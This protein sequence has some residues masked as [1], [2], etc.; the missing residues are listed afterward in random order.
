MATEEN[1]GGVLEAMET[2]KNQIQEAPPIRYTRLGCPRNGELPKRDLA[3]IA[4]A[5]QS[6][7]QERNSQPWLYDHD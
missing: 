2:D 4:Y 3:L 6:S 7:D 1:P 5:E